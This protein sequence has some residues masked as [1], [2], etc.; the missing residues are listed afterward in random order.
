MKRE[1]LIKQFKYALS[2]FFIIVTFINAAIFV[3]GT[4]FRP[5]ERFG[6][7]AFLSPLIYGAIS[8]IPV[9]LS[10]SDK[11]I[12]MKQMVVKHIILLCI[13]E[14][15][16]MMVGFNKSAIME[17]E[18]LLVVGFGL[19]VMCVYVLVVFTSYVLDLGQAKEMNIDLKAFQ[20]R[21]GEQ[22]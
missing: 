14:V 1:T 3:L 17:S 21:I 13:L 4:I 18:P 15:I 7:E 20:E 11:E 10:Y 6:Y 22:Q 16:L 5:E 8:I 19:S 12:S 2:Q 9:F